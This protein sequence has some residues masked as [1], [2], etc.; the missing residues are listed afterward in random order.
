ME[1]MSA[2]LVTARMSLVM[3]FSILQAF[4]QWD[5]HEQDDDAEHPD[6]DARDQMTP[7]HNQV[8]ADPQCQSSDNGQQGNTD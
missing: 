8:H 5:E 6:D 2:V 3:V 1:A 7:H 4:A